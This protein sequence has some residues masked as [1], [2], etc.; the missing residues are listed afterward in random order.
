METL[1]LS[2]IKQRD[3]FLSKFKELTLDKLSLKLKELLESEKDEIKRIV[4]L[5][6]RVETIRKRIETIKPIK[7]IKE[8]TENNI[9]ETEPD[10]KSEKTNVTDVNKDQ[11]WIRVIITESTEVNGVRFPEGIQVDVTKNDSERL[12][13]SGKASLIT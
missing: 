8:I 11:N 7:I 2:I 6:S 5:A 12:I 4:I 1:S 10:K 13:S 3:A 9:V